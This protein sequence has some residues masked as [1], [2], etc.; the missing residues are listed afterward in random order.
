MI[1]YRFWFL[2]SAFILMLMGAL[3]KLD[4]YTNYMNSFLGGFA[5]AAVFIWLAMQKAREEKQV[6]QSAKSF[7]IVSQL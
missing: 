5:N 2:A 4:G 7:L 1:K 6:K 3:L